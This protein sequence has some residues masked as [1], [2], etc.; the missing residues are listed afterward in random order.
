M[1]PTRRKYDSS[2]RLRECYGSRRGITWL[3]Y[4][5]NK[6]AEHTALPRS[7]VCAFIIRYLESIIA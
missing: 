4:A 5:N 2:H 6:G 3:L 7:L 1:Y